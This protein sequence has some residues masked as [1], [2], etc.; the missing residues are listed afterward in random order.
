MFLIQH[1]RRDVAT[2]GGRSAECHEVVGYC[3][4]SRVGYCDCGRAVSCGEGNIASS[5]GCPDR[6]NVVIGITFF[7]VILKRRTDAKVSNTAKAYPR[8]KCA[9]RTK[10]VIGAELLPAAYFFDTTL[11]ESYEVTVYPTAFGRIVSA[12]L[13]D[14]RLK[15]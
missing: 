4:M 5:S 10:V 3:A 2:K 13:V 8:M 6:G 7:D 1:I 9:T 12:L 11:S 14:A 15:L